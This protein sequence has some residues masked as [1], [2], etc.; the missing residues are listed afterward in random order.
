MQEISK[1]IRA[2]TEAPFGFCPFCEV[3]EHLLECRAKERLPKAAKTVIC[4]AFPYKVKQEAPKNISRYAAVPDY[5]NI[6]AELLGEVAD[7]LKEQYPQNEFE[8]FI[9]NSPIPEVFAASYAGLGAIG[10]N[11]LLITERFGSFVF[12]GEIVTDLSIEGG[13]KLKGCS[14]CG[15]CV[16]ACPVGLKKSE[17]LSAVTQQKS[18]LSAEQI[19]SIKK[20]GS[21]W[22]CDI[23]QNAC[24]HNV[25]VETTFIDEFYKGYR[26]CYLKGEDIKGRAY[27]WRGERVIL[28]NASLFENVAQI[29]PADAAS[30]ED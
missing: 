27:E 13:E 23:C 21:V 11:G 4:F 8:V 2:H 7:A 5:H 29:V 10:K 28:R 14:S 17:C 18:D 19:K 1:V 16:A 26:D 20:G 22:G 6:C 24:P 12:I 9:D 30:L 25:R 3:S 15:A